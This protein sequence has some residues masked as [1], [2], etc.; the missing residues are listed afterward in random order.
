MRKEGRLSVNAGVSELDGTD[1]AKDGGQD[2]FA[3]ATN[4]LANRG[5]N[6]GDPIWVDGADGFVGSVP[7][8]FITD[9]GAGE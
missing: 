7:A 2:A 3:E 5:L 4:F 8:F 1:L 9:A 6:P